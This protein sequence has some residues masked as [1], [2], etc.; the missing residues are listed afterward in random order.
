MVSLDA[1][2]DG[3]GGNFD[4]ASNSRNS[5]MSIFICKIIKIPDFRLLKYKIALTPLF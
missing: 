1:L 2:I 5:A 3:A 4:N